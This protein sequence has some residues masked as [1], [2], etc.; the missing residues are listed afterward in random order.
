MSKVAK[1]WNGLRL[2]PARSAAA[3]T[4][5]V[6]E[7]GVVGH[8]DGRPQSCSFMPLRTP[9][10]ALKIS[11]SASFSSTGPA[12]LKGSMPGELQRRFLQIGP[13]G[14]TT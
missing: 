10:A 12:G 11:V 7:G 1:G 2:R 13:S 4:K 6:V 5:A 3:I 14:A 9:S 8:Y